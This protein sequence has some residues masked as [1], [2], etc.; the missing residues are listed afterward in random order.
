MSHI[1]ISYSRK[2]TAY[3]KKLA[4]RLEQHGLN[5]WID[6]R[7]IGVGE[8]FFPAIV[9]A[10]QESTVVLVLVTAH[11]EQSE[12]VQQEV[13]LAKK[14]KKSVWPLLLKDEPLNL[15]L[16]I[17]HYDLRDYQPPGDIFYQK[18]REIMHSSNG[19]TSLKPPKLVETTEMEI[20]TLRSKI[21]P[22]LDEL[23]QS[24]YVGGDRVNRGESALQVRWQKI[25][26]ANFC[27]FD[28]SDEK[29]D[30]YLEM[31][32]ALA[33]NSIMI[34]MAHQD[35]PLPDILANYNIIRYDDEND[36][37]QKLSE[38]AGK[39]KRT[40]IQNFCNFCGRVC[41]SMSVHQ[42]TNVYLIL[43]NSRLP[44]SGLVN[45]LTQYI[46][47]RR[48]YPIRLTDTPKS[49]RHRLC[50]LRMKVLRGQF[51]IAHL[52]T[53]ANNNSLMALGMVIGSL[54]PWIVLYDPDNDTVPDNLRAN[55][56]VV[57]ARLQSE[58]LEAV[59]TLVNI[60][61]P[62][63]IDTTTLTQKIGIES[64]WS[65]I[66][67][68]L[69][70]QTHSE[71][72]SDPIL[73]T[74]R[75]I[76][77]EGNRRMGAYYLH[78]TYG[79]KFGRDPQCDV[80]LENPANSREHFQIVQG[81]TGRYYVV[82]LDTGSGTYLNGQRLAPKK[83]HEIFFKDMIRVMGAK[84]EIWDDRP[85]PETNSSP[86]IEE[87]PLI[88]TDELGRTVLRID[89]EDIAPPPEFD[90]W[91]NKI[92]LRAILPDESSSAVFEIQAYYPLGRVLDELKLV[93]KLPDMK[94][95]FRLGTQMIAP[96]KTPLDLELKDMAVLHIIPDP[97]EWALA[98]T[99]QTIKYCNSSKCQM[100][101][102]QDGQKVI[103]WV[104]GE[105]IH[106]MRDLF[107]Q[108]YKRRYKADPPDNLKL[109]AMRCPQCGTTIQPDTPVGV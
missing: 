66:D 44:W 91:D 73:G 100:V 6:R 70:T 67:D 12:W 68:W 89:F 79:L 81:A 78:P 3:A 5:V 14:F 2:D 16:G 71:Q 7:N 57:P 39:I 82:D 76:R 50:D 30:T 11:A 75:V 33:L 26:A 21:A 52:G 4:Q 49:P 45:E 106:S 56:H 8:E 86:V 77:I 36:F 87:Q 62:I 85:L 59:E 17:S 102:M 22:I 19:Q 109:P 20:P 47:Q 84:F 15:L 103:R 32:I 96:D 99:R 60:V 24:Y 18:L 93:A 104:Q 108:I 64:F 74:L 107:Q 43:D 101:E 1:F 29:P 25:Y 46:A 80:V 97:L 69:R 94:H 54:I 58:R 9:E 48:A 42:D 28:V 37:M 98:T 35:A 38:A 90:S 92:I 55:R 40:A 27:V 88:Q 83:R 95:R 34:V 23:G 53:L 51:A 72:S 13:M 105:R 63:Q 65:E 31:G 61:I 41:E 10:V